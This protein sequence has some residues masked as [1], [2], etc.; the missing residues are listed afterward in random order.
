MSVDHQ[1]QELFI[2]NEWTLSLAESCTGGAISALLVQIPDCSRYFLGSIV[3]YS[4]E[5]KETL[6]EVS[7][8]QKVSELCAKQMAI[9]A[10]NQFQSTFALSVTGSAGPTGTKIGTVCFGLA[11]PDTVITKVENFG[12]DR[13]EV[14]RQATEETLY[15]LWNHVSTS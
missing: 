3:S 2:Q 12:G 1:I 10:R 4:N 13:L 7:A 8:E 6:L 5:A 9:G 14:I 15:F 11:T